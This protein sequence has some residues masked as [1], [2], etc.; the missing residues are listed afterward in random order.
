MSGRGG[1]DGSDGGPP[2]PFFKSRLPPYHR[3]ASNM[4][5]GSLRTF[6]Y[7]ACQSNRAKMVCLN[8]STTLV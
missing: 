4:L 2:C 8:E 5:H 7:L 1:G 3:K 6:K